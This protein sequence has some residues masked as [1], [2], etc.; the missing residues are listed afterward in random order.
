MMS[1]WEKELN[2]LTEQISKQRKKRKENLKGIKEE[3]KQR[4][5]QVNQ[6]KKEVQ[7][8]ILKFTEERT[9]ASKAWKDLLSKLG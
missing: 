3:N 2:K 8:L 9:Q 5:Q 7:K 1:G 6:F 4:A